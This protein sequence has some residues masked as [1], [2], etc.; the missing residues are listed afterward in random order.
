MPRSDPYDEAGCISPSNRATPDATSPRRSVVSLSDELSVEYVLARRHC[1]NIRDML[2]FAVLAQPAATP[3]HEE[4]KTRRFQQ[5]FY[6]VRSRRLR[7]DEPDKFETGMTGNG[8][9]AGG[10]RISI[11]TDRSWCS[12]VSGERSVTRLHLSISM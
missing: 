1:V 10:C 4:K 11:L 2:P 6:L 12:L 8:A 9:R 3:S 5:L 7:A